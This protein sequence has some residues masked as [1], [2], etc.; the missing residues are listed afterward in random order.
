[1]SPST[2]PVNAWANQNAA[3]IIAK[4]NVLILILLQ[5]KI[6]VSSSL[7]VP[8]N[9]QLKRKDD[10]LKKDIESMLFFIFVKIVWKDHVT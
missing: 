4:Q 7:D 1:M 6:K 9:V 5:D 2:C 8:S 10:Y 3:A